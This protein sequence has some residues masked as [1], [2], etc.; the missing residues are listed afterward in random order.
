[1]QKTCIII[2]CYNEELR[3]DCNQ[4]V[5]FLDS[6]KIFDF[7]LVNDG[8]SDGTQEI[9]SHLSSLNEDRIRVINL[10]NNQGK[11]EAI[12]SAYLECIEIGIYD[13]IGFIDADFSAPLSELNHILSL[14]DGNL[15]HGIIAGSRVKRLGATIERSS[16]RHY[17]GRA[18]ATIASIIL[19]LSIY[20]SQCGLKLV[21][22]DY[23]KELFKDPFLTK[24][25]FDLEL[26]LRLRNMIG[27][28]LTCQ[29]TVEVPLN[30]WKE[31]GG[32]KIK[33]N[34][35]LTVPFDLIRIYLKYNKLV[36]D[37]FEVPVKAQKES[38]LS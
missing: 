30:E 21:R 4:F 19:K 24:W 34:S 18:F 11:A 10:Q 27:Y 29:E 33:M 16:L 36:L 5:E 31:K 37:S 13:Y 1:M 28:E 14:F 22:V 26:W 7:C 35:F 15:R 23:A 32:S 2:P 20:D 3:F 25:L 12:R 9:L 17:L 8:S 6:N 38:V